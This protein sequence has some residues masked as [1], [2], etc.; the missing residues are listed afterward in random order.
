MD[1][2]N[3]HAAAKSA[4]SSSSSSSSLQITAQDANSVTY[5]YNP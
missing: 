1:A 2:E 3:Q 4:H 5:P